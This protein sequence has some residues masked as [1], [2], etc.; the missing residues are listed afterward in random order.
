MKQ[1]GGGTLLTQ[2]S[3]AL[4][5][6]LWVF[7]SK[8]I[9]TT[10]SIKNFKFKDIEVEDTAIGYIELENN[11][12]ISITSSMANAKEQPITI[13]LYGEKGSLHYL[14]NSRLRI[15]KAKIQHYRPESKGI[16]ALARSLNAYTDW[17]LNNKPYLCTARDS[18]AV[19]E[20]IEMMYKDSKS[21]NIHIQLNV[22]SYKK[23][24]KDICN[25]YLSSRNEE[26]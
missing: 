21:E 3:H 22:D 1:S 11:K 24:L 25:N 5:I 7:N 13:D 8:P 2:G 6:L 19:L 9:R 18:L 23:S 15:L 16:H 10:T 4:D 26:S 12:L 20:C 14:S 17:I